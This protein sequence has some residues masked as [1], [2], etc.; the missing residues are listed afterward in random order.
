MTKSF[1]AALSRSKGPIPGVRGNSF[2]QAA[3]NVKLNPFNLKVNKPKFDVLNRS[4]SGSRGNAVNSRTKAHA[5]RSATI[6]PQLQEKNRAHT[7]SFIDRRFGVKNNNLNGSSTAL[8]REEIMQERFAREQQRLVKKKNSKFDLNS[9]ED[10]TGS[11]NA[12]EEVDLSLTHGGRNISQMD[13]EDLEN[14]DQDYDQEDETEAYNSRKTGQLDKDFVS[15]GHFGSGG[16]GNS[17]EKKSKQ[18]VMKELIAKS[19]FYKMERQ[20]IKEENEALCEDVNE[21]FAAIRQ[22]LKVIQAEDRKKIAVQTVPE[23]D[24][25]EA[26]LKEL[27]FDPRSKPSDR[28]L[29]PEEREDKE[30]KRLDEQTKA[31]IERMNKDGANEND[32]NNSHNDDQGEPR[33]IDPELKRIAQKQYKLMREFCH[34]GDIDSYT[35]LV[36]YATKQPRT[37]IQLARSIRSDLGKLSE[38]FTKRSNE[39][40]RGA[41]MPAIGPIRLLLLVSRIFS[42]SD[43][44]HV[45][46]TPSQ[47][48]LSYYLGVGRMTKLDHVQRALALVYC[49]I[50]FQ[51]VGKR[52]VPEA[53]QVLFTILRAS[54]VNSANDS[55]EA[56]SHYFCRPMGKSVVESLKSSSKF[57]GPCDLS[58]L[59]S[60]SKDKESPLKSD[61]L[62]FFAV[63]LSEE[64]FGLLESG[65]YPALREASRPFSLLLP[66]NELFKRLTTELPAAKS[67]QLQHH[68]P[69]SLPLLTP[70]FAADYSMEHRKRSGGGQD[71]DEQTVSRMKRAHKREY[72]GAVRELKRDA[73]FLST[74]KLKDTKRKDAEYKSKMNRIIGSIGN[75][76]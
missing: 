29:T 66:R 72:K 27:T 21:A 23:D 33:D 3:P 49:S 9:Y 62:I 74:H 44:H 63:K 17:D 67:L 8:S 31:L 5:V 71:A 24:E 2:S 42:C 45:V 13:D 30:K 54:S 35:K 36:E 55:I 37:M 68:K 14:Y 1:K 22:N 64:V 47:L 69:L 40:G 38:S 60:A 16:G 7:S 52:C 76:N 50:Q 48:L 19:K 58:R 39:N 46:A 59:F 70:D 32:E 28:T 53:L 56:A 4:V 26:T 10:K 65:N 57:K 34:T 43:Y 61:E 41:L 15:A 75:G 11:S 18:D 6:L 20:K 51:L 73:A 25:Y 12:S